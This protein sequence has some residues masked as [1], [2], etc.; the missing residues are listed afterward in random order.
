M[1]ET[2]FYI[3]EHCGNLIGVIHDA[4]VPMMCCGQKMTKLEAGV[5]DAAAEKHVPVISY[6]NNTVTVAIGEVEHPMTEAH[7]IAWVYLKTDKGAQ[8]KCLPVDGAPY[9]TFALCED[10]KPLAAFAYC[11]LHGLW[12]AEYE[13]PVVCTLSP[14]DTKTAQNYKVC[15][16]NNV[17]YFDILDAIHS[18]QKLETLLDTFE[19]V[20]NT[21]KCTTGC[22]GCYDK[23]IQ[24][25]SDVMANGEAQG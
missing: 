20:K 17:S 18:S 13:E 7:H 3:C 25:I 24:I 16:C 15:N 11:N 4:G 14:V 9:V 2:K 1:C 23:V 19:N 22:G 12:M 8:R 6:A 21:T 10:E 5:T